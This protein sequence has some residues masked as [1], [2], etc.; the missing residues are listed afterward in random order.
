MNTTT[1][2]ALAAAAVVALSTSSEANQNR[3]GSPGNQALRARTQAPVVRAQVNRPQVRSFAPVQQRSFARVNTPVN[4]YRAPVRPNYINS[5]NHV[6]RPNPS[7][8]F[9]GSSVNQINQRRVIANNVAVANQNARFNQ[10]RALHNQQV[11]RQ[12]QINARYRY[13]YAPQ[14]VSRGWDRR[15]EHSWNNHNYRWY[16][17]SWVIASAYPYDY[18]YGG[19]YV[20][21]YPE[22]VEYT[23]SVAPADYDD[24][25]SLAS[26]VQ[27]ALAEQG[28]YR[29]VIDGDVGPNTRNAIAAYQEAQRLPVTGRIDSRLLDSLGLE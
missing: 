22:T 11:Y 1:S 5:N 16:G 14:T 26:D 6:R 17:N 27:R 28:Y 15:H 23:T 20:N 3:G 4:N 7:I 2:L 19:G 8:A 29:G 24:G 18:S 13:Q 10:Q 21:D 25:D 12:N 9:G